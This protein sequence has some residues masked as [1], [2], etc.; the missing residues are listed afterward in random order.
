[1]DIA[2]NAGVIAH[3]GLLVAI[4][5]MAEK[6]SDAKSIHMDVIHS[7]L[8]K[9]IESSLEISLFR[10]IQELVTNIIKHA[11]AFHATINLNQYEEEINIIVE[12]NGKGMDTSQI[13]FKQGMGLHSIKTRVEHLEGS[14]TI[15]STPGK[16]TT[17]VIDI[18]I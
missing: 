4:E 5:L 15:D 6:I 9:P 8:E 1:M 16:G 14:S 17:I 3:E 10:I 2:K 7:G 13:N 18:P 11:Q 12:D